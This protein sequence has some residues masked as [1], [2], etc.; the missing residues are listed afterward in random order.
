MV[1]RASARSRAVA[2][3]ETGPITLKEVEAA[4]TGQKRG[5]ASG[6][7]AIRMELWRALNEH[8]GAMLQLHSIIVRCWEEKLIPSEWYLASIGPTSEV[9]N[10]RPISLLATAYKVYATIL[11]QRLVSGLEGRNGFRKGHSTIHAIALLRWI[12]EGAPLTKDT[13]LHI[14]FLDWRK[15]FDK[16]NRRG[17]LSAMRRIGVSEEMCEAVEGIYQ[18]V[19]FVVNDCGAASATFRPQKGTKQIK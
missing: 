15:A 12:M 8:P 9:A 7:D 11:Q 6:I 1:S 19:R 5:K 2:D 17:L 10:Y 14:A 16:V 4:L 3:I 13:E 18:D